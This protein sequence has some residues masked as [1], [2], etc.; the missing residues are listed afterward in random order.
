LLLLLL[1]Y[2][3][4]L[5]LRYFL[6]VVSHQADQSYDARSLPLPRHNV[7]YLPYIIPIAFEF[8]VSH[9]KSRLSP[10]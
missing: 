1:L 2:V 6:Y 3:R 8:C 10:V 7:L 4:V 5:Y 9:N